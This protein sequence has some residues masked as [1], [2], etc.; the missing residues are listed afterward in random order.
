MNFAVNSRVCLSSWTAPSFITSASQSP[1]YIVHIVFCCCG[2]LQNELTACK[3]YTV[4][5]RKYNTIIQ[6]DGCINSE[7]R[8][9]QNKECLFRAS[10]TVAHL[11]NALVLLS[12]E[13]CISHMSGNVILPLGYRAEDS[14][15]V[16]S[17]LVPLSL[18]FHD[19]GFNLVFQRQHETSFVFFL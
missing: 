4:T 14:R 8:G 7:T 17:R 19:L 18:A 11:V 3:C 2:D 12:C 16:Q 5:N 10:R 13:N 15:R 1:K 9:L 6:T